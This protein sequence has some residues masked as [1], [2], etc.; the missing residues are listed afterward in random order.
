MI[1]ENVYAITEASRVL[2]VNRITIRRWMQAGKLNGENIGGVVLLLR[3]DIEDIRD[4]RG[5]R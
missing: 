4:R 3:Q 1:R 2:G 5:A